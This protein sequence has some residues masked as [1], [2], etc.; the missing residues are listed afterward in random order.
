M[1]KTKVLNVIMIIAIVILSV[2]FFFNLV[3]MVDSFKYAKERRE[4]KAAEDETMVMEYELENRAYDE[5]MN[6]WYV[7]RMSDMEPV[8][9]YSNTYNIAEY[10]HLAFMTK[11]YEAEG[12]ADRIRLCDERKEAVKE[13]LGRYS[14]ISDEVDTI[15]DN[16][17]D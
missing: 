17:S 7:K 14:Y 8:H 10:C 16:L 2:V 9:G 11:V 13:K 4:E 1:N 3:F 6:T 15:I 12:N 5:I